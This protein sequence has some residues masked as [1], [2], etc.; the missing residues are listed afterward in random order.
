MLPNSK[1]SRKLS[2]P[3]SLRAKAINLHNKQQPLG[4]RLFLHM[5]YFKTLLPTSDNHNRN[6]TTA[7]LQKPGHPANASDSTHLKPVTRK[8]VLLVVGVCLL[9]LDKRWL[10]P[11]RFWGRNLQAPLPGSCSIRFDH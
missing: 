11:G 9:A 10:L 8:P 3:E 2:N 4:L 7:F 6:H 5:H 1:K